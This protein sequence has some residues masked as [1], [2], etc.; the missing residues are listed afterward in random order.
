MLGGERHR[1]GLL[2]PLAVPA[3]DV[4]LVPAAVARGG[5]EQFP[6]PG[7]AE[8]AHRVGG[9]VPEVEVA[10][11]P[12]AT[13][14]RCPAGAGGAGPVSERAGVR[15]EAPRQF[16]VP[17]LGD[18]VQVKLAQ[19]GQEPIRIVLNLFCLPRVGDR[20]LV[21]PRIG[22]QGDLPHALVQVFHLVAVVVRYQHDLL[23]KRPER[24]NR[25]RALVVGGGSQD[26]MRVVV[27]TARDTL[28][29]PEADHGGYLPTHML[30]IPPE[31]GP[32][33]IPYRA[34]RRAG[35]ASL[36]PPGQ[37]PSARR[38]SRLWPGSMPA[39]ADPDRLLPATRWLP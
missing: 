9:S 2:P 27:L 18:Q 22:V 37:R 8:A 1:G 30:P 23:G 14:V 26:R 34:R 38:A 25:D 11:D 15:A 35:R 13:G 19:R 7:A 32:V 10:G 29:L 24:A 16:L 4:V 21:R 28:N 12:D 3:A 31:P 5:H 39:A 36:R 20:E 33:L 6:P 17:A